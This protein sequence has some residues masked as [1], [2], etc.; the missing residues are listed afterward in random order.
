MCDMSVRTSSDACARSEREWAG[1]DIFRHAVPG[2]GAAWALI[3][4]TKDKSV[5]A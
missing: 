5:G 4:M 2:M 1:L 3:C